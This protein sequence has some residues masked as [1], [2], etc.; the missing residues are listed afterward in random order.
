MFLLLSR[1]RPS[2][3]CFILM[4]CSSISSSLLAVI[5][6][7]VNLN[8]DVCKSKSAEYYVSASE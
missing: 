8:S 4:S 5:S 6:K 1:K 2:V 3:R 7:Y